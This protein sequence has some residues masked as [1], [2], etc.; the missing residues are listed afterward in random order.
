MPIVDITILENIIIL[1]GDVHTYE[2]RV[3]FNRSDDSADN[4][5]STFTGYLLVLSES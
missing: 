3:A 2:L 5:Y 4:E 1:A